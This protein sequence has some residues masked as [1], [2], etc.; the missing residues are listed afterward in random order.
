MSETYLIKQK[1]SRKQSYNSVTE[2]IKYEE[3]S[4]PDKTVMRQIR[5]SSA[6]IC[7]QLRTKKEKFLIYKFSMEPLDFII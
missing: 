3:I 6:G 2:F 1:N 5:K 7:H 4:V